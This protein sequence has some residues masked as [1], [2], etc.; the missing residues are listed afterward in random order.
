LQSGV[1]EQSLLLGKEFMLWFQISFL[2]NSKMCHIL[3]DCSLGPLKVAVNSFASSAVPA[4]AL[5]Y[6]I[7]LYISHIIGIKKQ[8]I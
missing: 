3:S 1:Y 4:Q 5:N 7:K 2:A 8:Y 6:F